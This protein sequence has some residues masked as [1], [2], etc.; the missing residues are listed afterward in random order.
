MKSYQN[1]FSA[2]IKLAHV[3]VEMKKGTIIT[4]FKGGHKR[5]DGH[6]IV[7]CYP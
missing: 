4:L 3:P 2:M 6:Y 7:F 5:R 1:C